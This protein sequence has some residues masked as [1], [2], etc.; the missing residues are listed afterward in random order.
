M[1]GK[2]HTRILWRGSN[3]PRWPKS[4]MFQAPSEPVS[5]HYKITFAP[6]NFPIISTVGC[7]KQSRAPPIVGSGFCSRNVAACLFSL[8]PCSPLET[9]DRLNDPSPPTEARRRHAIINAVSKLAPNTV[10]YS[11]LSARQ[12]HCLKL[13]ARYPGLALSVLT[14]FSKKERRSTSAAKGGRGSSMNSRGRPSWLS[15]KRGLCRELHFCA[16]VSDSLPS[17]R[18]APT[19]SFIRR[20]IYTAYSMKSIHPPLNG[21]AS[22]SAS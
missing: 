6:D 2:M 13:A 3:R 18:F 20:G 21:I 14:G 7:T 16:M 5:R 11:Y 8:V 19:V 4:T 9:I 12:S 15:K 22:S 1:N 10:V 17:D